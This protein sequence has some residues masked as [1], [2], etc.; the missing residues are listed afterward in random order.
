MKTLLLNRLVL[1]NFKGVKNLDIALDGADISVYGQ[2]GAGKTTVVDAFTWLLFDKDSRNKKEF[3]IKTLDADNNPIHNL[4]HTVIGHF[5]FDGKEIKLQKTY[6][7]KWVKKNGGVTSEMKGHTTDYSINDVP[8]KKGEYDKFVESIIDEEE[9]KLVTS[10]TYFNEEVEWQKRRTTLLELAGNVKDSDVIAANEDLKPLT[11]LLAEHSVDELKK[12]LT[13]RKSLTK[14]EMEHI[15]TRIDE[16]H[17]SMPEVEDTK[18]AEKQLSAIDKEIDEVR[19]QI[20]N[21]RNG[22]AVTYKQQ[23]KRSLELDL[24]EL[25]NELEKEKVEEGMKLNSNLQTY[26]SDVLTFERQMDDLLTIHKKNSKSIESA[27]QKQDELRDR[28]RAIDSEVFEHKEECICPTC[29]QQLPED[30]LEAAKT[31]ALETFNLNKS[32]QLIDINS[33][34][35][36]LKSEIE[37]LEAANKDATVSVEKLKVRSDEAAKNIAQIEKQIE[38]IKLEIGE[39]RND[40]RLS[41]LKKQIQVVQSEIE[42]LEDDAAATIADLENRVVELNAK[43][44]EFEAVV[45]KKHAFESTQKRIKELEAEQKTLATTYEKTEH[46]LYLIDLFI[47]TKVSMLTDKINSHFKITKWKLFETQIN[48]G[49]NEVCV[50]TYNGVPYD[51]GLNTGHKIHVG[52]DIVNVLSTHYGLRAPVFIDNAESITGSIDCESQVIALAAT[53]KVKKLT[54]ETMN[55]KLAG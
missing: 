32:N 35:L 46:Q 5:T 24:K 42:K 49:I 28:Y 8:S 39:I 1:Q 27:R 10:P 45:A 31:K 26:K 22:Q 21:I 47:K 18:E 51:A 23:E 44:G 53:P 33:E 19:M 13:Q 14:K 34:G 2:N 41:E 50:A 55:E 40:E 30:K 17:L 4:E 36:R 20:A 12:I 43:K 3:G 16:L 7:E 6:K 25:Q 11:E 37:N 29:D 48:G 52:L 54:I 38:K 9:F 15:P